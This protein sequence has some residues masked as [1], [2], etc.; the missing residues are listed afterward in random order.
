MSSSSE[1]VARNYAKA[2]F[3]LCKKE[4]LP[5]VRDAFAALLGSIETKE[6]VDTLCNPG[7]NLSERAGALDDIVALQQKDSSGFISSWNSYRKF[8]QLV[9]ENGR[10][11]DLRAILKVFEG[12]VAAASSQTF[13][14]ITSAYN[15]SD[16]DKAEILQHL[17]SIAGKEVEC[18][19][20]KDES[21]IGG[22]LIRSG[23]QVLDNSIKGSLQQMSSELLN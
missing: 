2:L 17:H 8:F 14:E 13:L 5:A 3:D 22:L 21:I 6:V 18:V 12:L 1:K 10:F 20:V 23:D 19:W 4:E 15:L 9:L 7:L 11:F 16:E